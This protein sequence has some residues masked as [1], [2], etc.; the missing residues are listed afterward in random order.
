MYYV[1]SY[2]AN[3]NINLLSQLIVRR[4]QQ[5]QPR[6]IQPGNQNFW[7]LGLRL[8]GSTIPASVRTAKRHQMKPQR[9]W[10]LLRKNPGKTYLHNMIMSS[11]K[12]R[13]LKGGKGEN[14]NNNDNTI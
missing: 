3:T 12:M 6:N 1:L 13:S 5:L 8:P 10:L 4:K 11:L 2:I 9:L 14:D 7:S